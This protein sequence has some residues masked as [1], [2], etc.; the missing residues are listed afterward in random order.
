MMSGLRE[1]RWWAVALICLVA[2][3][4]CT[5]AAAPEA[6]KE[7]A[8]PKKPIEAV[9]KEHTDR[10]MALP[11]VVGTAQG[12]CAGE[13]CIKILVAEKTPELERQIPDILDGYRVEIVDTGP[14]RAL[15]ARPQ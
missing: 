14:I 9:L 15:P 5:Q 12:E 7:T 8:T 4:A 11:G 13:P 3:I 2:L 10:L 6:P 1:P